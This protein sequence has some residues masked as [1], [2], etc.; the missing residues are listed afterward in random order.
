[1]RTR[2]LK[3]ITTE[4]HTF[5]LKNY[6]RHVAH[7]FEK[8][9]LIAVSSN[10]W[11]KHAEMGLLPFLKRDKQQSIYVMRLSSTNSMSRP[12]HRCFMSLRHV[13]PMVRIFYTDFHGNWVEE[14]S[15]ETN[16]H[17]RCDPLGKA[18]VN[19]RIRS[20]RSYYCKH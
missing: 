2:V 11:G 15:F 8:K 7:L 10:E 6:Q 17:S 19:F 18:T 12:C 13:A 5:E 3:Q 1:M 14:T 9:K 16:H 4:G 20:K